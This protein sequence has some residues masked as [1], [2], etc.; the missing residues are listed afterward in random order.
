M[1]IKKSDSKGS[2]MINGGS[3]ESVDYG[4]RNK[5]TYSRLERSF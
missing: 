3:M 4:F 2:K 1:G 5:Y